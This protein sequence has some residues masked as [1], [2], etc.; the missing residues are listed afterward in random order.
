MT[1]RRIAALAAALVPLLVI[2]IRPSWRVGATAHDAVLMTP[3]AERGTSQRLADSL[4]G[5]PLFASLADA[6]AHRDGMQ[7]RALRDAEAGERAAVDH[8]DVELGE[9]RSGDDVE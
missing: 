5:A 1:P 7:R 9:Q 8:H 2:G 4:G 6:L 3:G